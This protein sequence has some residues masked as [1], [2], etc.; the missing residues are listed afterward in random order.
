VLERPPQGLAVDGHE[1]AARQ[2]DQARR[3]RQEAPLERLGVE[4]GE[5]PA[6]RVVAGDAPG[7]AQERPQPLRLALPEHGHLGPPVAPADDAQ[8]GDHDHV[9][10]PVG[11]IP[12]PRVVQ[13]LELPE[14]AQKAPVRRGVHAKLLWI[15]KRL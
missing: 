5:H 12:R 4:P 1:L 2:L 11:D 9:V 10:Q 6:E 14:E 3:P 8:D 7:Q 13:P 15:E